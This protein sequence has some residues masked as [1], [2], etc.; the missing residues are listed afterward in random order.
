MLYF[1]LQIVDMQN[2]LKCW[3]DVTER[4][5]PELVALLPT[6]DE[7]SL[8]KLVNGGI[9]TD[10]CN[11][12]RKLNAMLGD[13]INGKSHNLLCYNHLR[14]IWIKNVLDSLTEHLRVKFHDALEEISPE[15]RVSCSFSSF[16]RAFDKMFSLCANYPKGWGEI[17]RPWL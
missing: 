9:I 3:R 6:V 17:F 5:Y 10:T 15:F 4:E 13:E 1:L 12:A 16:A 14:N 8:Q 11:S 7:L 2:M